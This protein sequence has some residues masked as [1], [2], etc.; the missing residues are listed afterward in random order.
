VAA[1]SAPLASG[2]LAIRITAAPADPSAGNLRSLGYSLVEPE[3]GSG[4]LG[5]VF[6]DRVAWL[7]GTA[8]SQPQTLMGRAMAHEIGH[9]LMGTNQHSK[10]GLMRAVWSTADLKRNR[11]QDWLFSAPDAARLRKSRLVDDGNRIA[12]GGGSPD[13]EADNLQIVTLD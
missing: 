4:T 9:L 7:A 12:Q 5:T 1:C 8:R 2:E 6:S 3:N 11:R 10:K 13:P